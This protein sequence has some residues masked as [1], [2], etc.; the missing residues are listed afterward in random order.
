MTQ[1]IAES[2]EDQRVIATNNRIPWVMYSDY[3]PEQHG[4]YC[5]P[6][7]LAASR[8]DMSED[9]WVSRVTDVIKFIKFD[10]D[11]LIKRSYDKKN[12]VVISGVPE[13]RD[14]YGTPVPAR[15]VDRSLLMKVP[16]GEKTA[17]TTVKERVAALRED[18]QKEDYPGEDTVWFGNIRQRP[19]K[20]EWYESGSSTATMTVNRQMT[21]FMTGSTRLTHRAG[22]TIFKDSRINPQSE[23]VPSS[24]ATPTQAVIPYIGDILAIVSLVSTISEILNDRDTKR[25]YNY[26]FEVH[27]T[28][29]VDYAELR[30]RHG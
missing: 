11:P 18:I 13:S 10:T 16:K 30:R 8:G 19:D 26:T 4:A 9:R 12:W 2:V 28:E 21:T 14:K 22:D 1:E 27:P 25:V 5:I 7:N 23:H 3:D 20:L 29:V 15:D 24:A 6:Y 17:A